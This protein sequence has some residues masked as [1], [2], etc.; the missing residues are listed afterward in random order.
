MRATDPQ[1]LGLGRFPV[2]S[3]LLALIA[4][5][6]LL[7]ELRGGSTESLVLLQL[8]ANYPP[9]VFDGQ[10]FRLVTATLLH[11]GFVHL[12]MNGWA[13]FQL[14]RLSEVTF[15]KFT[16]LS[17]FVFTGVAGSA[18]TLLST[19]ISAGAS[20]ALF[21]LEGALVAFF[22]R[23]RERLTPMGKQLLKQLLVWSAFMLVYTFAVPGID[24]LGHI[25]GFAAGLAVGWVLRPWQGREGA[26]ARLTA[27]VAGL[28]IV[29][30]LAA[31]LASQ[32]FT[33]I[34]SPERGLAV[35]A[36]GSW[37]SDEG[38]EGLV[39][40]DSLAQFGSAAFVSVGS[41]PAGAPAAALELALVGD[42]LPE[43]MEL[44]PEP[45]QVGDWLRQTFVWKLP[46]GELAGF[47]QTRCDAG[48]CL[49]VLAGA[50]GDRYG[51]YFPLLDRIAAS[52]RRL[53][54]AAGPAPR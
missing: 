50:Q 25:G 32:R 43:G 29:A 7:E 46:G 42:G 38:E 24:W 44:G 16:T 45:R 11:I 10:W 15:G 1:R 33:A 5:L 14:G 37:R 4:A 30:S 17:L 34:E 3:G 48:G 21:G 13:L 31:L 18:L 2:T 35:D 12:L 19:K 9:L 47:A 36:P 20:G 52:A 27:V 23:H 51:E 28:V 22:L 26:F 40:R 6:F 54:P 53:P 8:G 49:V 41:E 39:V